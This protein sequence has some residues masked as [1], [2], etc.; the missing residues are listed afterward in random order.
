MPLDYSTR[1]AQVKAT[2]N[3]LVTM[4]GMCWFDKKIVRYFFTVRDNQHQTADVS[5]DDDDG[6]CDDDGDVCERPF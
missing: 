5:N 1:Y 4:G 3:C 2:L 6:D